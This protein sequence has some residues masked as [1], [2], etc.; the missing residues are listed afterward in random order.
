MRGIASVQTDLRYGP[1]PAMFESRVDYTATISDA[2]LGSRCDGLAMLGSQWTG[3]CWVHSN[4]D[5][6]CG[7][8]SCSW[9]EALG[10]MVRS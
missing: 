6:V 4:R 3:D 9:G 5:R 7:V 2:G 1:V 10:F 8:L